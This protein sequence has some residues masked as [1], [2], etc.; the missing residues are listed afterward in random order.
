ME[1]PEVV[2]LVMEDLPEDSAG[3]LVVSKSQSEVK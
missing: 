1:A 3:D 2:E